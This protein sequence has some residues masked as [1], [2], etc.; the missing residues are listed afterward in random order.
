MAKGSMALDLIDPWCIF[1]SWV[2][3]FSVTF[4]LRLFV[5]VSPAH[6]WK[7]QQKENISSKS[8]NNITASLWLL[9]S[10]MLFLNLLLWHPAVML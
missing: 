9:L 5:V 6:L 8:S 3:F 1:T 4:I 2:C 7:L 10:H